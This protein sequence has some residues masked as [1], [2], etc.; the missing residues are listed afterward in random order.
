MPQT[1]LEL[2]FLHVYNVESGLWATVT[3]GS[4]VS[5][6]IVEA[7]NLI[8]IKDGIRAYIGTRLEF[9]TYLCQ[10]QKETDR[11][12]RRSWTS[13]PGSTILAMLGLCPNTS[14]PGSREIDFYGSPLILTLGLLRNMQPPEYEHFK[15]LVT[16]EGLQVSFFTGPKDR[17]ADTKHV[18]V[19]YPHELQEALTYLED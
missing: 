5:P 16:S 11:G 10:A 19:V 17:P 9:G 7:M 1:A 18:I 3:L 2:N 12:S 6:H 4:P 14:R 15:L 8:L 13:C